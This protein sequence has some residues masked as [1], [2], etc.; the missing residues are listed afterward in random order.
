MSNFEVPRRVT[1]L[2]IHAEAIIE[3]L[4]AKEPSGRWGMTAFSRYRVQQLLGLAYEPFDGDLD[5]DAAALFDQ[6]AGVVDQLDLP[7]EDLSWRLA[8]ADA[9][10]AAAT[11]IRM[12]QDAY[13]V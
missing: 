12:V 13:D 6:A 9:L 2:V 8:L 1:D 7:I 11:D 5:V 4:E 10:R 3:A